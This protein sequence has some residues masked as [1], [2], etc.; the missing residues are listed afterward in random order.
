MIWLGH[1]GHLLYQKID[2][3]WNVI[4]QH[5][6]KSLM[7]NRSNYF[8]I[9]HTIC[10]SIFGVHVRIRIR[11][12]ITL[13]IF[14]FQQQW[15]EK[16]AIKHLLLLL[17]LL[18]ASSFFF[19]SSIH[20]KLTHFG[21]VYDQSPEWIAHYY[22]LD[23]IKYKCVVYNK[24]SNSSRDFDFSTLCQRCKSLWRVHAAF[25]PVASLLLSNGLNL[26][27]M[28]IFIQIKMMMMMMPWTNGKMRARLSHKFISFLCLLLFRSMRCHQHKLQHVE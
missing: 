14:Q 28:V 22:V 7:Q 18:R 16:R 4:K 9:L 6:I 20:E 11:I 8:G 17:L 26:C 3:H 1:S 10:V 12:H 27:F 2:H 25:F 23:N 5:N 15:T 13:T 19:L 21:H 24:Q